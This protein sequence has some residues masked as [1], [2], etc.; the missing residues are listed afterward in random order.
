M[1]LFEYDTVVEK[2]RHKRKKLDL[3]QADT[4]NGAGINKATLNRLE[5]KGTRN[6]NY[7]TIY[8]VWS[9]LD[10]EERKQTS[11]IVAEDIMS[12][13]IE[14]IS[15]DDTARDAEILMRK[16]CFSQLPVKRPHENECVGTITERILM[17]ND[18]KSNLVEEIM[19]APLVGVRPHTS[20]DTV[21]SLFKDDEDAVL[22][23]DPEEE[24]YSGIVTPADTF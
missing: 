4:A 19:G 5:N 15:P 17:L 24:Y 8:S 18:D 1:E 7:Q 13:N 3:N 16:R 2:L 14:W 22:V 23:K 11:S 20:K 10:E 9:Y 21:V 6:V 12:E